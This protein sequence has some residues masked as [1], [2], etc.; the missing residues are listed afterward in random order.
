MYITGRSSC[1]FIIWTPKGISIETIFIDPNLIAAMLPKL[2]V[3]YYNHFCLELVDSRHSRNL[4]L[5][6]FD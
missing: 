4:K 5:R 6:D 3:F 2:Q 1:D